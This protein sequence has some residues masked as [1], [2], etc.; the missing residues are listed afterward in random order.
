MSVVCVCAD[1]RDRDCVKRIVVRKGLAFF[2]SI[3]P[4]NPATHAH[5]VLCELIWCA[6]TVNIVMVFIYN[7]NP[8][9]YPRP[10][11]QDFIF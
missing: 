1:M 7:P 6:R 3:I 11:V 9:T 4:P 5:D 8:N 10:T 2:V